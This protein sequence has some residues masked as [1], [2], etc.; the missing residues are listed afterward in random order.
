MSIFKSNKLFEKL[1]PGNYWIDKNW[2]DNIIQIDKLSNDSTLLRYHY[3]MYCGEKPEKIKSWIAS[4]QEILNS[5]TPYTGN[6]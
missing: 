1:Q 5:F 4:P 6:I 2:N 3:V